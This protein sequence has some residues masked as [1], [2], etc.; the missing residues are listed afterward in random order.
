LEALE[1]A[2]KFATDKGLL[3]EDPATVS[4]KNYEAELAEAETPSQV[5]EINHKYFGGRTNGT[6]L[7]NR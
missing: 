1:A 2:Y 5:E 7:F 3:G 4:R 6:M